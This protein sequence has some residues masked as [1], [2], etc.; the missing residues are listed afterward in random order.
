MDH[1]RFR[2]EEARWHHRWMWLPMDESRR[3]GGVHPMGLIWN[4]LN[5][6]GASSCLGTS[7][8]NICF[9]L[10]KYTL[11]TWRYYLPSRKVFGVV[12]GRGIAV[13]GPW[14]WDDIAMT[15]Q[16]QARQQMGMAVNI[17]VI[18]SPPLHGHVGVGEEPEESSC[19]V[20]YPSLSSFRPV[21]MPILLQKCWKPLNFPVEGEGHEAGSR[22]LHKNAAWK[23]TWQ[24][25][26]VI[27]HCKCTTTN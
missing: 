27:T 11:F 3:G 23:E 1:E 26:L 5:A 4:S 9:F 24:L 12:S 13:G 25:L 8:A 15:C 16:E 14:C 17:S 20:H 21:R 7:A 10:V 2:A 19:W 6:M 22:G 18:S